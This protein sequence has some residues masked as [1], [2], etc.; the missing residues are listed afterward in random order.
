[1]DE[2]VCFKCGMPMGFWKEKEFHVVYYGSQ[3]IYLKCDCGELY[4][5]NIEVSRLSLNNPIIDWEK[6]K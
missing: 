6:K 4:N 5:L 3:R 1:M 2:I